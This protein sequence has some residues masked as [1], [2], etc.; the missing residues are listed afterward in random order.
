MWFS[1]NEIQFFIIKSNQKINRKKI[2]LI[3]CVFLHITQTIEVKET[4]TNIFL[5]TVY[6]FSNYDGGVMASGRRRAFYRE[7]LENEKE[8]ASLFDSLQVYIFTSSIH[9]NQQE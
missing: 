2:R 5:K 8:A 3:F 1:A 6:A 7:K 9:P 4:I